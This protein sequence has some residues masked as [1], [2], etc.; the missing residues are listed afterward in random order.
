MKQVFML[1]DMEAN[2]LLGF[3][4]GLSISTLEDDEADALSIFDD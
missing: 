1:S 2:Y 4:N 3:Y